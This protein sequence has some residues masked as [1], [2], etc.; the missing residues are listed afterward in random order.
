MSRNDPETAALDREWL[1]CVAEG[2][3]FTCDRT[4]T[5]PLG[6]ALCDACAEEARIMAA[7]FITHELEE[8]R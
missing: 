6:D 8:D 5:V 4:D 1:R 2:R 7:V 3:C